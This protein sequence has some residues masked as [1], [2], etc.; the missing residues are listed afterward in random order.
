MSPVSASCR[1]WALFGGCFTN[2]VALY[3]ALTV[4]LNVRMQLGTLHNRRGGSVWV[5]D[6][7][8]NQKE[9]CFFWIPGLGG[10]LRAGVGDSRRNLWGSC[11]T[12]GV[13]SGVQQ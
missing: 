5:S 11:L 12:C 3:S 13:L 4:F 8:G 10:V 2:D 1:L 9:K 6:H 7:G